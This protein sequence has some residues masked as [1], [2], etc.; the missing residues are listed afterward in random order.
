M[1][2]QKAEITL[3]SQCTADPNP[4]AGGLEFDILILS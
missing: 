1:Q 2:S 4:N 3:Y